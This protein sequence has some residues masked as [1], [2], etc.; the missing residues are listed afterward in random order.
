MGTPTRSR[1]HHGFFVLLRRLRRPLVVLILAYAVAIVGFVLLPG[2]TPDGRPWRMDF[3]HAVYFVSFLGSTIGLGEI[4]YPFTPLQRLWGIVTIYLTVVAWLYSFGAL[5]TVLQDPQL[6]RQWL[7]NRFEN[8]VRRLREPFYL[9]CGYDEAGRRVTR[10]LALD[11]VQVV[12]VEQDADRVESVDVDDHAQPVLALEGD[13]SDPQALLMAGLTHPQ[14]RGVMALTGSDSVNTKVALT[15]KLLA[16]TVPVMAVAHDHEWHPRMAAT[17]ATVLIN[18]FDVLAQ[19]VVI[20]LRTPSL[21]VVYE[22]LTAQRTTVMAP[23]MDMRPGRWVIA[24]W[25]PMARALRHR[26]LR[27]GVEVFLIDLALDEGCDPQHSLLGDPSDPKVLRRAKLDQ[28]Q[29]LVAAMDDDLGNLAVVMAARQMAPHVFVVAHQL[30]RRNTPAFRAMKVDL[31]VARHYLVASEVLRHTRAPLLERFLSLAAQEDEPWA[32]G[33][34]AQLRRDVGDAVLESW[35][36]TIA[37]EET[38]SVCQ[39]LARGEAVSLRRFLRRV[40]LHAREDD[41]ARAVTLLMVRADAP[42]LLPHPDTLLL[43]GDTLLLAGCAEA[44][45]RL[46]GLAHTQGLAPLEALG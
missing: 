24:G 19:R 12:V 16:P 23:L 46:K 41:S 3:L 21:H 10:E 42:Y 6:K 20:A 26:L 44:R 18:P 1:T 36:M 17:G 4:P 32:A 28:A 40:D 35:G 5:L 29:V 39:A 14:C 13:A 25:G 37:P 33:L 27:L 2:Q 43:P 9:L 7:A 8:A 31:L 22:A 30:Q 15:A 34:L 11:G 38:P 45:T